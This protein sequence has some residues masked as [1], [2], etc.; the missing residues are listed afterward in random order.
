MLK[1]RILVTGGAGF[2]GKHLC[3]KLISQD[4]NVIC[5]DNYCSST[6]N[7]ILHLLDNKNFELIEQDVIEHLK[8]DVDEIYHLA[9]PASP[10]QY[11]SNPINTIKTNVVGSMNMVELANKTNAK[12]FQASTSEIYG[13][14]TISPQSES[15]FGNVNTIGPRSCYDEGKRCAETIFFD[16]KRQFNLRIKIARIFN[17]YG[18]HMQANDGRVISNFILQ[19]LKNQPL[20]I[21][22]DGNQTRSFCYINDLIDGII[23]LMNTDNAI[24]EPINLGNPEEYKIIDISKKSLIYVNQNPN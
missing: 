12:I 1:K 20:T 4:N 11:K 23:N 5:L 10:F 17:T 13:D 21:Y 2:L 22:G 14:P 24:T 3:E 7:N 19:A 18:P 6:K 9:C 16:F 15:Y 8:I